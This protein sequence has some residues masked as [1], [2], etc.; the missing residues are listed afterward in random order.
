[1]AIVKCKCGSSST[2]FKSLSEKDFPGGYEE[3]CC[4]D[5]PKKEASQESAPEI[6]EDVPESEPKAE[7]QKSEEKPRRGPKLKKQESAQ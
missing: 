2:N 3:D 4:K 1:M 5:A 6:T 7:E